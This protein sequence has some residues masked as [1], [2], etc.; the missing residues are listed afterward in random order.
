[1]LG[2]VAEIS[3]LGNRQENQDR[4]KAVVADDSVLLIAIDGMGGHAN[5]A[6]AAELAV[7]TIERAF[8][9]ETHPLFDPQGFLHRAIARAHAEVVELGA[10]ISVEKRPRA[11]CALCLVQ[12]GM[13]Y[14]AHI[15]DSRVYHLRDQKIKERTR[16]HSHVE[17]LMYDG[18]ITAE[19]SAS[20]PMR[21][22]VECCLGG[23]PELPR[24]SITRSKPLESGD[25]LLVC[26]DG[27]WSPLPEEQLATLSA[28]DEPLDKKLRMLGGLATRAAAPHSDNTSAAAMSFSG[29]A[30]V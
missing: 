5:G 27:F 21:N 14:W 2:E 29:A 20:H 15:G 3:L 10:G 22:Y 17:V 18:V 24:M 8:V 25:V 9:R 30:P 16:D 13:T 1:M 7:E 26:S 28:S 23:D 6:R 12:D 19:E 4:V 11:T